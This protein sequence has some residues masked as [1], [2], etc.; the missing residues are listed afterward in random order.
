MEQNMRADRV[1]APAVENRHEGRGIGPARKR[2][3]L[4]VSALL[5]G[6]S[7]VLDRPHDHLL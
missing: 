3:S 7:S 5:I 2:S 4:S 6:L 1:E